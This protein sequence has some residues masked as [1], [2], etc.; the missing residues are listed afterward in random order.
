MIRFSSFE[1]LG[2]TV[3]AISEAKDG[4][5]GPE[6]IRAMA[7]SLGADAGRLASAHQVH[8]TKIVVI[9][10]CDPGLEADG[11][12]TSRPGTSLTVRVA[13]CVPILLF[14]PKGRTLG[15][16]HAGWRGTLAGIATKAVTA[17]VEHSTGAVEDLHVLIGP[18]AGPC[19]YRVGPELRKSFSQH[20]LSVSGHNVDLWASN[21]LQL[22]GAGVP[23]VNISLSRLC[24]L[25][26]TRFHSYR[27]GSKSSR[28]V[29]IVTI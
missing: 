13:D 21:A 22:E 17:L 25:C 3:A 20:G 24:T 1:S 6:H 7:K 12:I 8:G 14:D 26:D 28:N 18:S 4:D 5:G 19:C 2:L 23:P 11:L 15:L 9:P 10:P 27:R 16:V 29:V